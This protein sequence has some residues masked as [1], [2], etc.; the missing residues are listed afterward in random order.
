MLRAHWP[1]FRSV[2]N[3][4]CESI[5]SAPAGFAGTPTAPPLGQI[6]VAL[7][8]APAYP[9]RPALFRACDR[10]RSLIACTKPALPR[11]RPHP[12]EPA[13]WAARFSANRDR[14]RSPG[15]PPRRSLRAASPASS[16]LASF[17]SGYAPSRPPSQFPAESRSPQTPARPSPVPA[18]PSPVRQ[19]RGS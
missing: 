15:R 8:Q 11:Y 6:S 18:C 4:A 19:W 17:F 2:R 5:Y 9:V 16:R 13:W 12:P 14:R 10:R 7:G 1:L 3:S